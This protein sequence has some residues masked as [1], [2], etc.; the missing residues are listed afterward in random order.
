MDEMKIQSKIF[1]GIISR[2]ISKNLKKT[3]GIDCS[4]KINEILLQ[5]DGNK[6][7]I[8]LNIE[9]NIETTEVQKIVKKFI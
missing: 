4:I 2:I 5:N 6:T 9:G 1:T 8:K 7:N 3:I